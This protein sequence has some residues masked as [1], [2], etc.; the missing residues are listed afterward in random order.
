VAVVSVLIQKNALIVL[1]RMLLLLLLD[2]LVKMG[3]VEIM[4]WS[5]GLV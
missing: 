4:S 2:A 5:L 3:M 1:I